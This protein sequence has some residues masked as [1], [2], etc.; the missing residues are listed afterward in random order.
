MALAN[1]VI[2][3]APGIFVEAFDLSFRRT[4]TA[5]SFGYKVDDRVAL[6]TIKMDGDGLAGVLI[7]EPFPL[8][9]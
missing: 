3:G 4:S 7:A 1:C 8:A 5:H 6:E 2:V 9:C